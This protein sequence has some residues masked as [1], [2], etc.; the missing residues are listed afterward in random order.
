MGAISFYDQMKDILD[1][2]QDDVDEAAQKAVRKAATETRKI[3]KEK[4]PRDKRGKYANGWA[5]KT[6]DDGSLKPAVVVYNRKLPGLT[7]LLEKGHV[8]SNQNGEFGRSPAHRHIAPAERQG[9]EI[10]EKTAMKELDKI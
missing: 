3:L 2:V 5:T 8:I 4:S 9:T 7:Q 10:F 1:E 6:I